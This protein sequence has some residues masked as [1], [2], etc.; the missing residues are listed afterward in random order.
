MQ[1]GYCRKEIE[2]NSQVLEH[3]YG[4]IYCSYP[5]LCLGGFYGHFKSYKISVNQIK[6]KEEE[7]KGLLAHAEMLEDILEH[8]VSSDFPNDVTE[9]VDAFADIL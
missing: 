8:I 4:K 9:V 6:E 1:C 5:C 2:P 3:E 7:D